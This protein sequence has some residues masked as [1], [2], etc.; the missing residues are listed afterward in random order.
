VF[1]GADRGFQGGEE[2]DFARSLSIA[3]ARRPEIMLV[4]EMNGAPLQ[5]QHGAPVRLLV[6]GWYGMASVKWLTRIE[7]IDHAFQ[8]YQQVRTYRFKDSADDLGEPVQ[9][10]RVR[11]LMAP[12]GMPDYFSRRRLV[13]PGLVTIRGRAWSGTAPIEHVEVSVDGEWSEAALER[14]IGRFAWRGWGFDWDAT[15][16]EHELS[17]RA[18][19]A[20]GTVQPLEMP[21]NYGGMGNNGAQTVR[22]TVRG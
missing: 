19:D 17:C 8:G 7:A 16:G 2:H 20:H 10:I 6:P 3:D 1:T 18:T 13:D 11:A 9:Q 4:D 22:V 21:W 5:P 12:P 14:P 15:P